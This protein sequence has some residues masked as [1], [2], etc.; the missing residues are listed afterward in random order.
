MNSPEL[1]PEPNICNDYNYPSCHTVRDLLS[2]VN[3]INLYAEY[4]V[5]NHAYLRIFW[6][7]IDDGSLIRTICET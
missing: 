4:S 1:T 6:D 2:R 3:Q 5:V 7:N